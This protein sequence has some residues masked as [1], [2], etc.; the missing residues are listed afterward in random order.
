[1]QKGIATILQ[2]TYE[3]DF[4]DGSDGFRPGRSCHQALAV[5]Q[6]TITRRPIHYVLEADIK[7]FLDNVSPEWMLRCLEVRIQDPSLLLRGRTSGSGLRRCC[8]HF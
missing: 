4:P 3:Q 5:V 1:M 8:R 2:V 6:E 7:G